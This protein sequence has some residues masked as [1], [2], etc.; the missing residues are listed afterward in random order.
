MPTRTLSDS[1]V[2][3]IAR[4]VNADLDL[5]ALAEKVEARMVERFQL[6][7][8]KAVWGTAKRWLIKV[9]IWAAVLLMANQ[10][11]VLRPFADAFMKGN[12]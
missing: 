7:T 8:G 1:D 9:L 3:A 4:R 12:Q 5:D 10:A 2:A 6:E 11:G